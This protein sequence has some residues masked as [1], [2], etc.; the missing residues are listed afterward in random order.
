MEIEE[1]V[2][3]VFPPTT[4]IEE[5]LRK[6]GNKEQAEV[7]VISVEEVIGWFKEFKIDTLEINVEGVSKVGNLTKVFLCPEGNGGCKITLRPG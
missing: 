1:Q 6:L 7:I 2:K 4:H 5:S 3:L